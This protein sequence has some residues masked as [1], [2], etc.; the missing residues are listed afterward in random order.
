[1]FSKQELKASTAATLDE[2]KRNFILSSYEN[3]VGSD[4]VRM[5][6]FKVIIDSHCQ[7]AARRKTKVTK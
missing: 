1:M 7:N 5:G 4:P 6:R 3:R 2:S